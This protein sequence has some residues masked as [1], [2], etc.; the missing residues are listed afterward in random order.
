MSFKDRLQSV[1][2]EKGMTQAELARGTDILRGT[3]SKWFT[4]PESKPAGKNLMKIAKAL[5]VKPEWLIT[6]KGAK[7]WGEEVGFAKHGDS[8]YAIPIVNIRFSDGARKFST[9]PT[10][11]NM[12]TIYL[13][14]ELYEKSN[15]DL[16][17]LFAIKIKDQ[18]ME[19]S[20]YDGDW[21]VVNAADATPKSGVAFAIHEEKEVV[22][23]RLFRINNQWIISSDN[24][25]KRIYKDKP[26]AKGN[27]ILGR[28]VHK[29]SSRI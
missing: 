18:A 22:V 20:L 3:V 19:P 15:Y 21:V 10:G 2:D 12:A 16:D 27:L 14:A 7:K 17:K 4:P 8:H 13:P 1:L 11:D 24:L 23:R 29:Q 26:M 28:V 25:D 6:G 9:V 5:M